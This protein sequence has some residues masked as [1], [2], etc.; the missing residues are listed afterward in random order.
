M[1]YIILYVVG[2]NEWPLICKDV[3]VL[4]FLVTMMH[5]HYIYNEHLVFT[6]T[7]IENGKKMSDIASYLL[8]VEK[9]KMYNS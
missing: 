9:L 6:S 2:G 3:S 8:F 5:V 7:D 4:I 1:L